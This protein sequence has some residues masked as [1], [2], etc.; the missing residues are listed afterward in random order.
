MPLAA[1]RAKQSTDTAGT[2][3]IVL[4]AAASN[5]RS[6][7]AAF[8]A[9]ARRVMYAISW[10]TGFEIGLGDFDGG[11]PGSLTRA[12]VLASS[13]AG[14]LVTLPAGTKDVFAVFDP[15]AREVISISGTATL[16]L[17]DLGNAVVFTGASA[18]TLN[19]PAAATAPLGAGW[20][21]MNNGTAA[22]T[23]DPNGAETVN[24]AA[25]L[26]LQAGAS[27]MLVRVASAWQAAVISNNSAIGAQL[28]AAASATAAHDLLTGP[29]VDIASAATTNIGAANSLNVRITGTTPI[30]SL[31][32]AAAGI[33][34]YLRFAAALTLTHN[35]TSLI[36][37]GGANI[38]TAAGDTAIVIS[39]GS[40]NWV[41]ANYMPASG[42]AR[43]GAATGSGLTIATARV[44]GRLAAGTGANEEIPIANPVAAFSIGINRATEQVVS[45]TP[46][47]VDFL[48]IPAGVRE[49]RVSFRAVSTNGNSAL[50]I[51]LGSGAFTTTGYSSQAAQTAGGN[52]HNVS[53]AG[54]ILQGGGNASALY[55]GLCILENPSGNIWVA[56]GTLASNTG[57][58]INYFA[59]VSPDLSSALD[60]LRITT[61]NGTDI[62]DVGSAFNVSWRF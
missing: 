24:G 44:L 25:T 46:V 26:V 36:L 57:A 51:Q 6:F 9:S 55:M 34:R 28:V 10:A 5:A 32:T 33:R 60:R 62:F 45:G 52:S 35:A 27:A 15:A 1:Y 16:A 19:L 7:N 31:G 43:A 61:V 47:N 29:E 42:Y 39:L 13:N 18:A 12:T 50:L 3:T 56:S 2:G 40:G 4:N 41:L 38:T 17:A 54:L 14:A 21:V 53:T 59:G 23:I 20:L 11:T 49:V 37:P 30:T 58:N 8:G 22:L 48:N